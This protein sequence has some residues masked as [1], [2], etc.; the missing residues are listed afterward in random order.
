MVIRNHPKC[1][2]FLEQSAFRLRLQL[3]SASRR[4]PAARNILTEPVNLLGCAGLCVHIDQKDRCPIFHGRPLLRP[5][6]VMRSLVGSCQP[7]AQNRMLI[8]ERDAA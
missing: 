3:S 8:T 7:N 1:D 5:I 6:M 2:G 4:K